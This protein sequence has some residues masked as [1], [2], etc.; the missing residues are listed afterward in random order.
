MNQQ[1]FFNFF[2][3][4]LHMSNTLKYCLLALAIALF[5]IALL[6]L[7]WKLHQYYSY[8]TSIT[9]KEKY[10][11]E[12][13]NETKKSSSV[14]VKTLAPTFI[15]QVRKEQ[16]SK[17][18]L[19]QK[20]MERLEVHLTPTT[21]STEGPDDVIS[22]SD[23]LQGSRG[24]LRFSI[25]YDKKKTTLFIRVFEAI[26]LP[27][28]G[29]DPFVKIKV[30]CKVDEPKS[31]M[32]SVLYEL[33]T[34]VVKRNQNPVFE[35]EFFCSLK[36]YQLSNISVKFEVKNFDKYS[37]HTL[38]GEVRMALKDLKPLETMEFCEKLQEKTKDVIGEVLISLKCL[39]TSQKIEVGILKFKTASQST[40]QDRDVYARID[41]FSNQHKQKHQK[42]SLR[43]KSKVTVFNETFLFSLPDPV[44]TQCLV[45]ISL[46]ETLTSGRK[47]IGQ[48][49][50]GNQ[51]AKSDDGH[52]DLM[53]QSLRQPVALWH[54]LYI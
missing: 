45:L 12:G 6:I 31:L 16:D 38:I 29:R 33:E 5:L 19:M 50:L 1:I 10:L 40:I 3:M 43:A 23:S 34:R 22:E 17:I 21:P 8:K 36:E 30:L 11:K 51:K 49:S 54:P 9:T 28:N 52:W 26:E 13:Y 48:T 14:L 44:K 41:V 39:P 27:E 47:L 53:M 18:Q 37:R 32:H 35:E 46:Y 7:S 20:E 42:S 24:K 15:D 25:C 2:D 4:I